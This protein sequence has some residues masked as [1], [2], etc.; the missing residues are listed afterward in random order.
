[1][2]FPI[3]AWYALGSYIHALLYFLHYPLLIWTTVIISIWTKK[4]GMTLANR[5]SSI[6]YCSMVTYSMV[7]C[8]TTFQNLKSMIEKDYGNSIPKRIQ[9]QRERKDNIYDNYCPIFDI[10]IHY[11]WYHGDHIDRH[12][13]KQSTA[14]VK[15][16]DAIIFA[17]R[18]ELTPT[19]MDILRSMNLIVLGHDGSSIRGGS[20]TRSYALWCDDSCNLYM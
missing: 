19:F 2:H 3:S 14:V 1:M 11:S 10:I 15:D 8:S 20:S 4:S 9:K 5:I 7:T 16:S 12:F 6:M 13:G 17:I 18:I